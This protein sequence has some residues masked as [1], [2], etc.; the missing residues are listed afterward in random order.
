VF[1][2]ALVGGALASLAASTQAP[3]RIPRIGFLGAASLDSPEMRL[4]QA[5]LREGLDE[6][7]YVEGQNIAIELAARHRLP[8]MSNA[9]EYVELGGLMSYGASITDLMRHSAVYVD[10][11]LKGAKPGDLPVEQPTKF[12]LL[13]NLKTARA[14]GLTI[15]PSLLGRADEVIR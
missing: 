14:L 1:L 6:R 3:S 8:V 11:I 5:A 4:S 2:G 15:P 13:I 10:R 9:R 12:E 7:G